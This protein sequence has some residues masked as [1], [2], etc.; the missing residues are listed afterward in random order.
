MNVEDAAKLAALADEHVTA[1][2]ARRV[3]AEFLHNVGRCPVC[4]DKGEIE[5]GPHATVMVPDA[6]HPGE[7]IEQPAIPGTTLRCPRCG[8]FDNG[9]PRGD[10]ETKAWHCMH[11]EADLTCRRGEGVDGHGACEYRLVLPDVL[12][13]G[14]ATESPES[15]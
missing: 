7:L 13:A 14:R 10:P 12:P 2:Q 15:S 6:R 5:Y 3:I 11:G 1:T 4:D 9:S 8:G